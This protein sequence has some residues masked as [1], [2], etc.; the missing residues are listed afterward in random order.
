M[1][2]KTFGKRTL[3]LLFLVFGLVFCYAGFSTFEGNVVE[4]IAKTAYILACIISLE[5][6]CFDKKG[7]G[8]WVLGIFL[9]YI[10]IALGLFVSHYK[11]F[12]KQVAEEEKERAKEE[13]ERERLRRKLAREERARYWASPEGQREKALE[14]EKKEEKRKK[15]EEKRKKRL[16][17]ER[18]KALLNALVD[19]SGVS[20]KV[21]RTLLDQ[22]PTKGNI[23][24]AS[25]EDLSSVP[26]VGKSIATAIKAR[27]K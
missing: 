1:E 14:E 17:R 18:R 15:K 19:I 4:K 5:R 21:A 27:I 22:F 10:G 25:V 3:Q 12:S 20:D 24:K 6:T 11:K 8:R 13:K 2:L 7:R 16:L 26:G 23:R 9:G